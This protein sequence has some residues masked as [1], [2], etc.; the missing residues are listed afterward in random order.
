MCKKSSERLDVQKSSERI[1]KEGGHLAAFFV[2][3]FIARIL[4]HLFHRL[5][6][7]LK[8]LL[9]SKDGGIKSK[10]AEQAIS[11]YFG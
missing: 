5:I 4:S 10:L 6:S 9:S 7:T 8:R 11:T 3:Y 1:N 2:H